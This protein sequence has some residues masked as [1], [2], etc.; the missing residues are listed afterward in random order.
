[1]G[2]IVC[3]CASVCSSSIK[4]LSITLL[5]DSCVIFVRHSIHKK[6]STHCSPS[7]HL[8]FHASLSACGFWD[9]LVQLIRVPSEYISRECK[10]QKRG[11]ELGIVHHSQASSFTEAQHV[12]QRGRKAA[13][14]TKPT[15]FRCSC[16]S[17]LRFSSF[18]R[19][20]ERETVLS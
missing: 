16:F 14:T 1:M 2:K 5:F 11:H 19:G 4:H 17:R 15:H 6:S 9:Q 13:R 8:L 3:K 20:E 10:C 18:L 7:S 12:S